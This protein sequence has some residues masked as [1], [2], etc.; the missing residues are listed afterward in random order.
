MSVGKWIMETTR[1][2]KHVQIS[3]EQ[4]L[5]FWPHFASHDHFPIRYIQKCLTYKINIVDE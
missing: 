3:E 4:I 2:H 1:P 5:F